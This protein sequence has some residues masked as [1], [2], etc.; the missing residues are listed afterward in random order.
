MFHFRK[1]YHRGAIGKH[2][3]DCFF[4]FVKFISFEIKITFYQWINFDFYDSMFLQSARR[5]RF[6]LTIN[7]LGPPKVE[8][9]GG[10]QILIFLRYTSFCISNNAVD[11]L[12]E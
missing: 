9:R 11:K 1:I 4:R 6:N 12:D 2:T 10:P 3:W 8:L 5:R 7:H